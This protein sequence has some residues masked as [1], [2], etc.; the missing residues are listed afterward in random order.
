MDKVKDHVAYMDESILSISAEASAAEAA[1]KMRDSKLSSLIV[2]KGGEN[3]GIVTETDLSRKII[4][5]ELNPKETKV[6][7]IMNKPIVAIDSDSTMM[8]AFVKM[9]NHNIRHLAVTEDDLIIGVL[10]IN[11]FIS[12]Y[13]QKFEKGTK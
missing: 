11:N 1:K 13:K 7:F 12:Y 3:W 6:K 9:G 4:A 5:E 8:K 10:S 2:V